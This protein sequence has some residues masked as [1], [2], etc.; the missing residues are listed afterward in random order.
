MLYNI[1][2]FSNLEFKYIVNAFII[3]ARVPSMTETSI[4]RVQDYV[5][6]SSSL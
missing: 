5:F 2:L 6:S 3:I 4:G 1:G